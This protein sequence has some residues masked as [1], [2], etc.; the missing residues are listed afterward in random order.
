[1]KCIFF[2]FADPDVSFH[3]QTSIYLWLFFH[4]PRMNENIIFH[5]SV[6]LFPSGC[7]P[8]FYFLCWLRPVCKVCRVWP[9]KLIE[10]NWSYTKFKYHL[11]YP[12]EL[13]NLFLWW[14]WP[15]CKVCRGLDLT[16]S[17]HQIHQ[18]LVKSRFAEQNHETLWWKTVKRN[19]Q[20][21]FCF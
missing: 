8:D 11:F 4:K 18:H 13:K 14:L 19:Y 3:N 20:Q 10:Y 7:D 16:P 1:M 15:R 2:F 9:Q 6:F 17:S 5:I 12:G 21:L